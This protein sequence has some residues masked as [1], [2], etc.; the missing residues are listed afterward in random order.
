MTPQQA[1]NVL[2]QA[3][4]NFTGTRQDHINIQTAVSVLTGAVSSIPVTET[5]ESSPELL[6]QEQDADNGTLKE[7]ETDGTDDGENT[8]VKEDSVASDEA[9]SSQQ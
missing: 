4:A 8:E 3:S 1:L 7:N 9:D 6:K 2:D 5:K